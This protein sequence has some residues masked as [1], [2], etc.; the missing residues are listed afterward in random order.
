MFHASASL[1]SPSSSYHPPS[2]TLP[3]FPFSHTAI[4][5]TEM[6]V[7]IIFSHKN[8]LG[9]QKIEKYADRE[10]PQVLSFPKVFLQHPHHDA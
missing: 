5:F 8:T 10:E 3:T 7:V 9:W 4:L 1:P 2:S 6:L